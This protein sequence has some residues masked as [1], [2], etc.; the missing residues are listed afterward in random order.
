MP[1]GVPLNKVDREH[2]SYHV[3]DL[4]LSAE[5]I[6]IR[7][8]EGDIRKISL[9]YLQKLCSQIKMENGFR[10]AYALGPYAKPGRKSNISLTEKLVMLDIALQHPT[11][12]EAVVRQ[13]F[14]T[15]YYEN[16]EVDHLSVSSVHRVICRA[17][18]SRKVVERRHIL[19]DDIQ[20]L[21]Y[22]ER[23]AHHN[24]YNF[25][26]IDEVSSNPES[27]QTRYGRAPVGK[28]CIIRQI[29]IGTRTFSTIAAMTPF[30]FLCWRIFEGN[31]AADQFRGFLE[32]ILQ[33]Y[34]TINNWVLLDNAAQHHTEET[35]AELERVTH[36]QYY[37]VP[38]YSPHLKPVERGFKLV[39]EWI[40][41]HEE[42][43]IQDPVQYI[44][45]AFQ[46]YAINGAAADSI[47][48]LWDGYV[49]NHDYFVQATGLQL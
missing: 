3:L 27:F 39:K 20:G 49:R 13:H 15:T 6:F 36:G 30:G 5:E 38:P 29:V 7:L 2:V 26:D 42:E 1:R 41:S 24:P 10:D 35:R 46:N 19:R 4:G 28:P 21:D 23:I 25:I 44:N 17:D 40:R 11:W 9:C 31:V 45:L 33:P 47:L 37:Y 14:V 32:D 34:I 8:F 18:I 12:T 16:Q 48:H 22:M 43:A